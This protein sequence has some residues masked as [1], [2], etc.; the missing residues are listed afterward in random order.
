ME[1]HPTQHGTAE[2]Q[3]A[4]VFDAQEFLEEHGLEQ[5]QDRMVRDHEGNPMP[6]GQAIVECQAARQAIQGAANMASLVDDETRGKMYDKFFDSLS[7]DAQSESV[8]KK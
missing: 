7:N 2:H 8:K 1:A 5:Y 6:L 4:E 3:A